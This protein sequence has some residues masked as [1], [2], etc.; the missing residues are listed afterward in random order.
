M[1][2]QPLQPR[3]HPTAWTLLALRQIAPDRI[4]P[5]DIQALRHQMDMDG[6]AL[7]LGLGLLALRK[8]NEDGA[9]FRARLHALQ[10]SDGSWNSNPYHTALALLA[11]TD[12]S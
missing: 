7:A 10:G 6:G 1:F 3:A 9:T 4:L 8:L 2:S 12:P 11:E 5:D